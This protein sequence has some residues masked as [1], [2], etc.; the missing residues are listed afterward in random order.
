MDEIDALVA[1]VRADGP[2]PLPLDGWD[3]ASIW[4]WDDAAN[5]LFA[6]LWRNTDDPAKPPTIRVGPDDFTPAITCPVTLTQ[7]IAIA[8]NRDPWEVLAAVDEIDYQD[9]E[10]EDWEDNEDD[11]ETHEGGT[12]VTMTEGYDIWWPPN[13]GSQRKRPA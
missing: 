13:F 1:R 3:Q 5:S 4:G 2:V 7:H 9:D 10:D 6:E 11:A 12:V 8:V